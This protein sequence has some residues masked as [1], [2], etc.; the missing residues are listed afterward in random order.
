MMIFQYSENILFKGICL[1]SSVVKELCVCVRERERAG[2]RETGAVRLRESVCVCAMFHSSI[3]LFTSSIPTPPPFHPPPPPP[4]LSTNSHPQYNKHAYTHAC[5]HLYAHR[6][7]GMHTHSHTH[8]HTHT[9]TRIHIHTHACM[10]ACAC[11]HAHTLKH[12][13]ASGIMHR[14][15]YLCHLQLTN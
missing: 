14:Y 6:H 3:C 7:I 10:Y 11:M 12:V 9:H 13:K 4:L 1:S 15:I 2:Q 5:T 8:T